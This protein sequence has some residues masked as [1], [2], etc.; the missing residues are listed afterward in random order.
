MPS[1]ISTVQQVKRKKETS[2]VVVKPWIGVAQGGGGAAEDGVGW[3]DAGRSQPLAH[4][5]GWQGGMVA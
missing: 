3:R 5:G 1:A 4:L 2:T